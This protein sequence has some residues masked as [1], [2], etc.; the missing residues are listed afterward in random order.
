MRSAAVLVPS[1][2]SLEED[3]VTATSVGPVATNILH[4]VMSIRQGGKEREVEPERGPVDRDRAVASSAPPSTLRER[5]VSGSEQD[6][7][8]LAA[9]SRPPPGTVSSEIPELILPSDAVFEQWLDALQDGAR[10]G[11]SP[12]PTGNPG[13]TMACCAS[14]TS[15]AAPP[16]IAPTPTNSDG[17]GTGCDHRVDT[18]EGIRPNWAASASPLP[19]RRRSTRGPLWSTLRSYARASVRWLT[20]AFVVVRR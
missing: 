14:P 5:S 15:D 9:E 11:G 12:H 6:A 2:G 19:V 3:E 8:A 17:S 10:K 7:R 4:A 1:R 18:L 13:Q 20:L 16:P